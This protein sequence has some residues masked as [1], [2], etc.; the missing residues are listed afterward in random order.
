MADDR[1]IGRAADAAWRAA[2]EH[3]ERDVVSARRR[4]QAAGR[5]RL[6]QTEVI[7]VISVQAGLAAA[8]AAVLAD[9]LLGPGAHVFAPSA[10]VGTIA[11]AIGQRARRTVELLAGVGL[12]IAVGDGLRFL[13]GSGPWQ[14]GVM[15]ALAISAALLLSGR[16]SALVGQAGGTAVLIATLAPMER[17]LELPRILDA[18]V[19]AVVGIAVVTLL[20][21]VNPLRILDKATKP[22]FYSL[23]GQLNRVARALVDRDAEAAVRVLEDLRNLDDDLGRMHEALAGADEVVTLAPVRWR[24]RQQF[25]RYADI[26]QHLERLVVDARGMSRWAANA[27]QYRELMPSSLPRGIA[28]LADAIDQLRRESHRGSG[29]A[30][31]RDMARQ[32]VELA[33]AARSGGLRTYGD[34]L[35]A[36]LRTAASDVLRATGC[37]PPEANRIVRAAAD[38]GTTAT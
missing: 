15:V 5:V 1:R 22:I 32:A 36:D 7:L 30:H 16:G 38:A 14:T 29:H 23:S 35:V 3:G 18:L 17:G 33:A 9:H 25:H 10:A 11:T 2:A 4:G 6:R 19:G 24:R 8:L 20:L 34:G 13:L 21:P 26:A 31:S 37:P 12:G 27:L 28:R